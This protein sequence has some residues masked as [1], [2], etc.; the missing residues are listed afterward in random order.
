MYS[1]LSYSPFANVEKV[2]HCIFC[3]YKTIITH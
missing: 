3:V 1:L 2:L